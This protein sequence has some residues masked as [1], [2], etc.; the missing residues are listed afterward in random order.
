[1]KKVIVIGAGPGGYSAAVR[2]AK[3]GFEVTLIDKNYAGGTCLNVGCI[4]TKTLLDNISLFEHFKDS[5]QKKKIFSGEVNINV[6]NLVSQQSEVIKQ[7]T[8][9]LE[10]LFQK[11]KV[12]FIKGE[13]K[14][15]SENK[16]LVK[17][18]DGEQELFADEIII[19]TGSSPR[20]I[21]TF[22][23][24]RKLIVSSDE[25][26]NVPSV[27][28]SLLIVGSGPIGVEFARVFNALGSKVTIAEIKEFICPIVDLEIS[29]NLARSLKR[30]G[31]GLKP[32]TASK[33]I[34]KT[35]SKVTV[36]FISTI[37]NQRE[38]Q[39]FDQ[40]LIAVGRKPNTENINLEK[41]EVEIEPQGFIKVNEFLQT[42][43]KNIWAIGDITNFP[44]LAH[45]A[46]AQAKIVA[47][48]ISGKKIKFDGSLIPGCIFGYPEIAFVG[49]T[50]ETLKEKKVEYKTGKFLFLATGKAKASGLTEGLVKVLMDK[51]TRKILGAHIL[52]AEASNLIH[53]LV[54]AMQNELTVDE[55]V[56]SIHA[57]PTYSEVV[58]EALEDCLGESLYV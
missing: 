6:K 39:D 2:L 32:N 29:E 8:T 58:F 7:L 53:E 10:K 3:K 40:V 4:P 34:S 30:R 43:K 47:E 33:F 5:V 25:I 13:A 45:T 54:V 16:V 20:S 42:N 22:E 26:W 44:Q 57:H 52:G 14:L 12:N 17:K 41:A 18:V 31:I 9:G 49:D 24:D 38:T 36:E 37:D 28:E 19:A 51:N 56:N 23:F 48:N 1:M 35:N 50:E 27:P 11:Q 55:I 46:S 21:P 15:I